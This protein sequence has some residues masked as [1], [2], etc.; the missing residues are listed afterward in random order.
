MSTINIYIP[1]LADSVRNITVYGHVNL[2]NTTNLVNYPI[3]LWLDGKLL[4]LSNLTGEGTYDFY[5][6]FQETSNTEFSQGTFY[7]YRDSRKSKYNSFFRSDLW[8][9]Y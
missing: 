6:E 9:F 3:N 5:K 2:T 7:Q 4:F 8:K 1:L